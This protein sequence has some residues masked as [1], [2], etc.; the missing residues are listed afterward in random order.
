MYVD[1]GSY[2][3]NFNGFSLKS[4]NRVIIKTKENR[5][6][7]TRIFQDG[8]TDNNNLFTVI[9]ISLQGVVYL[10]DLFIKNIVNIVDI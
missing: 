8:E 3:G 10:F 2:V 5:E 6:N 1:Q 9:I 4:L 7:F